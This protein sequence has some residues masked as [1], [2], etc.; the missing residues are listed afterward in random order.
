MARCLPSLAFGRAFLFDN[1]FLYT[2]QPTAAWQASIDSAKRARN[3]VGADGP[4][5]PPLTSDCSRFWLTRSYSGPEVPFWE[6]ATSLSTCVS[7]SAEPSPRRE[8]W[9]NL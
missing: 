9:K 5:T 2:D 1:L 3:P 6:V 8:D 4:V 7:S